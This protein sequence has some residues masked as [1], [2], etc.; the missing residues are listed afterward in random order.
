MTRL[1]LL[2][3]LLATAAACENTGMGLGSAD[4]GALTGAA[5]GA[6]IGAAVADDDEIEGAILGGAAGALAGHL[7]GRANEPGKCYYRDRYGNR[8]VAECP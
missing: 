6:A 5:T 2:F 1:L 8:Y 4:T 3:P 7:I